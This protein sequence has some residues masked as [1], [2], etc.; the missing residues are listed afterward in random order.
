MPPPSPQPAQSSPGQQTARSALAPLRYPMFRA[1]AAGRAINLVGNGVAPMALSFAVLDLTHSVSDLGLVVGSRSLFNVLFL[2][3]GGVLADRLPR[4]LVLVGSGVL[5][6]AT[7]ATVAALV[8]TH[9]A[10]VPLLMVL[11]AANGLFAALALPASAALTPQ[12]VPTELRQPANALNRMAANSAQILGTSLGGILVAAVGPGWGL[13]VDASSFALSALCFARVRIPVG[14]SD[15]AAE[16]RPGLITELREGWTEFVSRT[17]VWVIVVAF[18]FL[19]AAY[20]GALQILGPSIAVHSFGSTGWGFMLAMQTAGMVAGGLFALRFRPRHLLRVGVA[21]VGAEA[22]MPLGLGLRFPLYVLVVTG[23]L[24]GVCVEQ[25]GVAWETSL[26]QEIPTEKLARVY[27]YDMVGSFVAI[28][29][30]QVATGPLAQVLGVHAS[31]LGAAGVI[32]VATVAMLAVPD[33]RGLRVR[34]SAAVAGSPVPS[35]A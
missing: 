18:G 29:V 11:S 21:C 14:A 32:A 5:S 12:T 20:A 31:L 10:T 33:V 8:L 13:V 19:N 7:Q 2:L 16:A 22:L 24:C 27:S 34:G 6:A 1:V 17:W 23:F 15:P 26:Q 30:A 4:H 3:F 35:P 9:S 25:F 28:P